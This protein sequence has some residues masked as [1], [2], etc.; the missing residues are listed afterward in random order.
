MTSPWMRD[1]FGSVRLI[2]PTRTTEG[3]NGVAQMWRKSSY[4]G[5]EGTNCVEVAWWSHQQPSLSDGVLVRDSKNSTGPVLT[6]NATAWH[7]LL[8]TR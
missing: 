4:S 7:Q 3:V 1:N 5:G 6:V 8:A 2:W